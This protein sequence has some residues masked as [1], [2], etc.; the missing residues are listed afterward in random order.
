MPSE[1]EAFYCDIAKRHGI[2]LIPGSLFIDD[3]SA[4]YNTTPIINDS[5]EIIDRYQ[6]IYPFYP[7]EQ[8]V[9]SGDRFVVFDVPGKGR[10][11]ISI[12]YD[13][14]FPEVTRTL[15]AMG[16]EVIIC[17]TMTGTIDRD[18]ELAIARTNSVVGQCYFLNINNAGVLGVGKSIVLGPDGAVLHQA[19]HGREVIPI[20][21]DFD[22][23]RR[24]RERGLNGLGQTLKSFRDNPVDFEIYNQSSEL[25][26]S[27]FNGIG[28]LKVPEKL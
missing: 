12:C 7:Y 5:G 16:A 14:W 15:A 13:Q 9:A 28:D 18:I 19:S 23:V 1:T 22:H 3:A 27:A 21:I 11:G 17:P 24:V 4:I 2:W 26:Q 25:R 6:K 20:E 8:G 10:I